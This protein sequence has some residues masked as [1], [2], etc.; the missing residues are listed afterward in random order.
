MSSSLAGHS[1]DVCVSLNDA[2]CPHHMYDAVLSSKALE[3]VAA[4]AVAFDQEIEQL[5]ARRQIR[6]L[7]TEKH[8]VM[9]GRDTSDSSGQNME[10]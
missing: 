3:F 8:G 2:S 7:A 5:H 4:L 1:I 10:N 9:P 6:R